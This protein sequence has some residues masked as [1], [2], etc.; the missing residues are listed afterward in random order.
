MP[1]DELLTMLQE[2]CFRYYWEAAHPDSGSTLEN[3]PGDDR[4][5]ATGASGLAVMALIVGVDRGFI[6]R[7]QG[8]ERLAKI[9]G[10]LEKAPRYHGAWSHF[11]D[12]HTGQSLPVFALFDNAGDLVETALLMEG[13]LAARQY[14]HAPND[15]ERDLSAKRNVKHNERCEKVHKCDPHED[16]EDAEVAEVKGV[17]LHGAECFEEQCWHPTETDQRGGAADNPQVHGGIKVCAVAESSQRVRERRADDE[18]KKGED[19]VGRRPAVPLSV[20]ERPVLILLAP[21]AGVVDQDHG[22]DRQA[23]EDIEREEAAGGRF[24]WRLV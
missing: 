20:I 23:A 7:E 9:V 11:M 3:I 8:A 13:L 22:Q 14:F 4:I 17:T 18:Q 1:D 10:F 19:Q 6:T 24:C 16:A 15:A 5:V 2:Q 12:G 21:L